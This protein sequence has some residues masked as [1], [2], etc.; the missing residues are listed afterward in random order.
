MAAFAAP[1]A[2]A[3]A[4]TAD[5][6]LEQMGWPLTR[7]L[8]IARAAFAH[9][10]SD[11]PLVA[12]AMADADG[13]LADR[14]P[15]RELLRAR[16]AVLFALQQLG[17]G[18]T[19]AQAVLIAEAVYGALQPAQLAR[20]DEYRAWAE[21]RPVA[22]A[23]AL[24]LRMTL[25]EVASGW[26]AFHAHRYQPS[27]AAAAAARTVALAVGVV[28]PGLLD[29]LLELA[30][31]MAC[32]PRDVLLVSR[33]DL[34]A[35]A[36]QVS[37]LLGERGHQVQRDE[38]ERYPSGDGCVPCARR[39]LERADDVLVLV[40]GHDRG[41]QYVARELA[42]QVRMS[43]RRGPTVLHVQADQPEAG[44]RQLCAVLPGG[45]S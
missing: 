15:A 6:R 17:A 31:A 35:V 24:E 38:S 23:G 41:S 34:R 13:V 9:I 33:H 22:L 14:T 28:G 29:E 21:S 36:E 32:A 39:L 2:R 20:V 42:Q 44:L 3:F 27:A 4:T 1:E 25:L 26:T 7:D 45:A 40:L 43:G 5:G 10:A 12:Q 37:A 30:Q 19:S 8:R 16:L 11:H 18:A